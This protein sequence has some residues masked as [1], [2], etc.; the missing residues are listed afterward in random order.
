MVA[1]N[2]DVTSLLVQALLFQTSV[3]LGYR[4]FAVANS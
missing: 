1:L 3:D 4:I 2:L